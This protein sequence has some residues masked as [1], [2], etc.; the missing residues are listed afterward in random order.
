MIVA[1]G[2]FQFLGSPAVISMLTGP[3]NSRVGFFHVCDQKMAIQDSAPAGGFPTTIRY[4]R[5]LPR[6]G[7][8][9]AV[10]LIAAGWKF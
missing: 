9:G 1:I 6:R 3:I 4:K 2:F 10:L 7:P 5:D 8:S